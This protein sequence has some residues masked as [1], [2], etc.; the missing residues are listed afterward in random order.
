MDKGCSIINKI[1]KAIHSTPISEMI[2]I[3]NEF[4]RTPH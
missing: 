3:E 1:L 2:I 4:D